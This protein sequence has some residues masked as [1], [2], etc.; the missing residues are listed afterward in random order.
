MLLEEKR[1]LRKT[2]VQRK[3]LWVPLYRCLYLAAVPGHG[4]LSVSNCSP[5]AMDWYWSV[6]CQP[7][8]RRWVTATMRSF[9]YIYSCS[10]SLTL[11]SKLCLL[12]DQW[13]HNKYNMLESSPNPSHPTQT[14]PRSM[15]K[16]SSPKPVPGTKKIGDRC[17]VTHEFQVAVSTVDNRM[18]REAVSTYCLF[19]SLLPF[20]SYLYH[21]CL[22]RSLTQCYPKCM[23]CLHRK[24]RNWTS[25]PG[26]C[27]VL[28][29]ASVGVEQKF[30]KL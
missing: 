28:L 20:S 16:L 17:H 1:E 5:R 26:V 19:V 30:C 7:H 14:P 29:Y 18:A 4:L 23:C 27:E 15:E 9:V 25:R 2:R 21:F 24:L 3:H 6:A 13:R 11:P 10:P 12:S 8:G 22:I